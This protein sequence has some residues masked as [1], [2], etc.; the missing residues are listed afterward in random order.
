[1]ERSA[2][3]YNIN[4]PVKDNVV[5]LQMLSTKTIVERLINKAL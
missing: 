3:I 5:T 2:R 4:F 1:M